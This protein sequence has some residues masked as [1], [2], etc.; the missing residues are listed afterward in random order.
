MQTASGERLVKLR[1]HE[2]GS[3]VQVSIARVRTWDTRFWKQT[4]MSGAETR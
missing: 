3:E 1:V 4:H 2:K